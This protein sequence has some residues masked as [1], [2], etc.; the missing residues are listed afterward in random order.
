MA[1][2]VEIKGDRISFLRI[3]VG[4]LPLAFGY[5][6][7]VLFQ[8]IDPLVADDLMTDLAIGKGTLG[9]LTAA[10]PLAFAVCLLPS[11]IAIDRFG[12]RTVQSVMM[13]VT[14]LGALIFS[15]STGPFGLMIGRTLL[16]A[17][18]ASALLAGMKAVVTWFPRERLGLV[19]GCLITVAGLGALAMAGPAALFV[20]AHGWR[21]LF[22]LLAALAALCAVLAVLLVPTPATVTG[23]VPDQDH[24][25]P[26][27]LRDPIFR[28]FA[29][30]AA[31]VVGTVWAIQG[32]WVAGWLAAVNGVRLTDII[33][34]ITLI[35]VGQTAGALVWG[36]LADWAVRKG[37]SAASVFVGAVA[38]CVCIQLAAVGGIALPTSIVWGAL[39]AGAAAMLPFV[40]LLT[41]F[42]QAYAAR[43]CASVGVLQY[44]A[45]LFIQSA[46]GG[47]VAIW[48]QGHQVKRQRPPMRWHSWCRS[49]CNSLLWPGSCFLDRKHET[50]RRASGK[51]AVAFR[52]ATIP[53]GLP[54]DAAAPAVCRGAS[55][56]R[57]RADRHRI[58]INRD[59]R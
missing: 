21:A 43:A 25:L 49:H 34:Y 30:L 16:G 36:A 56:H 19:T 29:P 41:H 11:G 6:L 9:I 22:M 40:V 24:G 58:G 28:R 42:P 38:L 14:A 2:R 8:R 57:G 3:M 33:T 32:Q 12:P 4:F 7:S 45:T 52:T 27:V 15:L 47:V 31:I 20:R 1:T 18:A 5:F 17:G 37:L 51:C 54:A 48:P 44:V 39:V 26:F 13:G 23:D 46:V 35:A 50:A 10:F 55:R 53:D 59:C